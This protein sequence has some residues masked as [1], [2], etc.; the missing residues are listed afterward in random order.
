MVGGSII[1]AACLI[2]LG[3]S[4]EIMQSVMGKSTSVCNA[5]LELAGVS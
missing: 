1:V 4:R 5:G 3:W 2:T